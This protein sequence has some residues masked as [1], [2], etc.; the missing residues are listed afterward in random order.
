MA[1]PLREWLGECFHAIDQHHERWDGRGYPAGFT[2]EDIRLAGRIV[3]VADVYDV[4]TAA[5]SYKKPWPAVDARAELARCAGTQFDPA[6]VR[7]FLE[8]SLGKL[9]LMLGPLTWLSEFPALN[10]VPIA[11]AAGAAA[12]AVAAVATLVF[13]GFLHTD[14]DPAPRPAP[15]FVAAGV[16][17]PAP[18]AD[19]SPTTAPHLPTTA[20]HPPADHGPPPPADHGPPPPAD[21]GS[22][23]CAGRAP[24]PNRRQPRVSHRRRRCGPPTTPSRRT[25]TSRSASPSSPTTRAAPEPCRSPKWPT[26]GWAPPRSTARRWCTRRRP[27]RAAS[28]SSATSWST[29]PAPGPRAPSPSGSSRPRTRRSPGR[30]RRSWRRT[31]ARWR[32]TCWPTTPTPTATRSRS[33]FDSST[34]RHGLLERTSGGVFTYVPD[35]D[36]T[37]TETFAYVVADGAGGEATATVTITVTSVDDPPTFTVAPLADL[38]EDAGPQTVSGWITGVV[39]GPPDE[40]GQSVSFSVSVDAPHLFATAPSV[41]AAGTLRYAPA[42]DANGTATLTVTATDNDGASSEQVT[43]LTITP[44]DDAPTFA[45]G[46]LVSGPEDAEPQTVAGWVT[47]ISPGPADEAGQSVTFAISVDDPTLFATAPSVDASGTLTYTPAPDRNGT[48]TLTI[49]AIDDAGASSA[50]R[51]AILAISPVDDPPTFTIGSSQ[52]ANEDSGPQTVAG[53]VT[54]ISPGPVDE[55]SQSV[56]F[57]VVVDD[58]TLFATPPSVDASGTL[59]YT[60]AADQNGT[61]TLTITATDSG[62][63][64]SAP[65]TAALTIVPVDDAPA[66]TVGGPVTVAEDAAPVTVAAWITGISPG[67]VDEAG[68]TVTFSVSV[69]DPSL[70]AADPVVDAAGTL[71]FTPAPDE[72]GTATVTVTASD[73]GGATS[74]SQSATITITPAQDPPVAQDD[75]YATQ[76]DTPIVV[77]AATGL[78]AN[79][80]DV[81][82]DALAVT[83]AGAAN[84]TVAW[85]T[86]GSFTYTPAP[87]ATGTDTFT[88]TI[89]DGLSRASNRERYDPDQRS[90]DHELDVLPASRRAVRQRLASRSAVPR[91]HCPRLR[92]RWPPGPHD[93]EERRQAHH[94]RPVEVPELRP[95]PRKRPGLRRSC[96]RDARRLDPGAVWQGRPPVRLPPGLRG[97]RQRV[98]RARRHGC[99]RQHLEWPVLDLGHAHLHARQREPHGRGGRILRLTVL[100]DHH[101]LWIAMSSGADSHI[102]LTTG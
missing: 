102:D 51:T 82:A 48:A 53:W 37:G 66:F 6:V 75:S 98:P 15:V 3:A 35:A 26:R 19:I 50:P 56:S 69:D 12:S 38:A 29:M 95:H 60:P 42:P 1:A 81:D 30:T 58:P 64:T 34:V 41:D 101:D 86:D 7:A 45:G 23:S 68:Q 92:R 84:G 44:V 2:G 47:D 63:A 39:V 54:G 43:A 80:Y 73:S 65:R 62:G 90:A 27:T 13:G 67:P 83:A 25:R 28:T 77:P 99:A 20:P 57:T 85:N 91:R 8:V 76:Q 78:L 10:R 17:E 49:T 71:T 97:R 87:G 96:Q 94:H 31:A 70:F 55:A 4:I 14:R 21:H 9:R 5:R 61:A 93:Q 33:R 74:P 100:N 72:H 40:A 46:A 59:T 79:D 11:P 18:I 16:S 36:F 89:T 24:S 22:R 88:Y 32:S 52:W